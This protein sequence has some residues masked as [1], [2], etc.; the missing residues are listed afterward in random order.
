[1]G[2]CHIGWPVYNGVIH[3]KGWEIPV[4]T[5]NT[6][7]YVCGMAQVDQ[8]WYCTCTHGTCLSGTTSLPIPMRYLT[9]LG[10]T[11]V[12]TGR[13]SALCIHWMAWYCICWLMKFSYECVFCSDTC[14]L[15][16]SD[17]RLTEWLCVHGPALPHI[18]RCQYSRMQQRDKLLFIVYST[19]SRQ[20]P[21]NF[22]LSG[23]VFI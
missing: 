14:L 16:N 13:I 18:L 2:D 3:W 8:I 1:M 19:S 15:A 23:F 20:V 6:A 4:P 9:H 21:C 5:H 22:W 10:Y 11:W 7:A 17:S 12:P